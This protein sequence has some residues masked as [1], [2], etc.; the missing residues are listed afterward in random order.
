MVQMR[1][2]NRVGRVAAIDTEDIRRGIGLCPKTK[3]LQFKSASANKGSIL[4]GEF[5]L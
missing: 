2:G 5:V 4:V 3:G 1:E